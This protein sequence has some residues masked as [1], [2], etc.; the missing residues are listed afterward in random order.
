MSNKD[1]GHHRHTPDAFERATRIVASYDQMIDFLVEFQGVL[2]TPSCDNMNYIFANLE[3][4]QDVE[5]LMER[6]SKRSNRAALA[7]NEAQRRSEEV[8]HKFQQAWD[9]VDVTTNALVTQSR[10]VTTISQ[11]LGNTWR[12]HISPPNKHWRM[13]SLSLCH[14]LKD[15]I[16]TRQEVRW[17]L[18][19]T[20]KAAEPWEARYML[21]NEEWRNTSRDTVQLRKALTAL[22]TEFLAAHSLAR[23]IMRDIEVKDRI[24]NAS[25][26]DRVWRINQTLMEEGEKESK[27]DGGLFRF[28]KHP[29]GV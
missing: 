26:R 11:E 18:G 7:C 23:S 25:E 22:K 29:E 5:I 27:E 21:A 8:A 12:T 17:A 9:L 2:A 15:A 10:Y 3:P 13:V 6:L 14:E 16:E 1:R 28:K 24:T 19:D 20:E 4:L